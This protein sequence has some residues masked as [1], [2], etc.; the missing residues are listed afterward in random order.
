MAM[1]AVNWHEGMFL[2]PQHFQASTR[3]LDEVS[4]RQQKWDCHYSWGLRAIDIDEDSLANFR[5][6]KV[7]Y[8][9]D[10]RVRCAVEILIAFFDIS[11]R[12]CFQFCRTLFNGAYTENM[13][14]WIGRQMSLNRV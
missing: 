9:A 2:R 14:F 10:L 12:E 1:H 13:T 4:H 11:K 6:V 7:A 5:F 8:N 3:Y